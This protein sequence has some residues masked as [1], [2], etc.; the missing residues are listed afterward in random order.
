MTA[1]ASIQLLPS[2]PY[3]GSGL[4]TIIIT[5]G[6]PSYFK[7]IGSNLDRITSV[8]W[9]PKNPASV[10]FQTRGM[11]LLDN[12]TGT[13]M[14]MVTNNYLFD[15]DRAGHVS[16]RL[17]DGSVLTAPV[18]TYGRVSLGPLWSAPGEGLIT[19]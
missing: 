18:K 7:V 9:Y 8:D 1:I 6:V 3:A 19:G 5:N 2:D 12:T 11:I 10:Q 17:D 14:I 15:T 4:V 16:F 13:F